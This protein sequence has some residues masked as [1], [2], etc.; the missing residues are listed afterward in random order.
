MS[1]TWLSNFPDGGSD[2]S[3]LVVPMLGNSP[4]DG[5]NDPLRGARRTI[6]FKIR[7]FSFLYF[8][9]LFRKVSSELFDIDFAVTDFDPNR[10]LMCKDIK[11]DFTPDCLKSFEEI[12]SALITTPIVQAPDWSLPFEIMCD[13]SDFAVGAV[14][15]QRREKKLHVFYYAS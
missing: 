9:F 12:K 3:G 4:F 6:V 1:L 15:G 2:D 7:C 5:L 10:A 8:Y 11:F 14:L 13:S